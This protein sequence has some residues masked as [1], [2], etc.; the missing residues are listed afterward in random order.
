[1]KCIRP[2]SLFLPVPG[3]TICLSKLLVNRT[4][5]ANFCSIAACF[6]NKERQKKPDNFL[7][8]H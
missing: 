7:I 4:A 5:A 3:S 2:I 6:G 1:M 8:I